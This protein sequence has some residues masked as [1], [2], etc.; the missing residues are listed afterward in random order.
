M[1]PCH[2][3]GVRVQVDLNL[4]LRRMHRKLRHSHSSSLTT[5]EKPSVGTRVD[6]FLSESGRK[7]SNKSQLNL[8]FHYQSAVS[9]GVRHARADMGVWWRGTS[10]QVGVTSPRWLPVARGGVPPVAAGKILKML[11]GSWP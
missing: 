6:T 1:Q 10:F 11:G 8:P 3:S 5:R 4:R 2:S 7:V 9:R